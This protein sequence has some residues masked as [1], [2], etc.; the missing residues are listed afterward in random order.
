MPPTEDIRCPRALR[1]GWLTLVLLMLLCK[2]GSAQSSQEVQFLPEI[3]AYLK[4]NPDIR[5]SAQAKDTRDGGESTQVEIGPSMEFYLK[6]LIRLREITLFDLDD[7]KARPL[8]L[9]VG[10]R[11]LSAPDKPSTNRIP[12][13]VTSHLPIKAKLLLTDRNRADLDWSSG[14]FTWRYRN[15]LSLER[16]LAIHSYHPI[17]YASAEI[18]YESQYEKVSTTEIYAGSLFPMG[19]HFQLKA[20]YEHQNNTGKRPNKQVHGLGL[21]LNIYFSKKAH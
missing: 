12:L 10:Y 14:S 19:K 13:A 16:T 5:V 15:M 21:T 4:L 1:P 3:D 20:Y 17:P 18:Y 8:V 7:A 2:A 9:A 11:Y 6:P